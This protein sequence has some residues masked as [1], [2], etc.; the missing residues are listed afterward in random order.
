M[1]NSFLHMDCVYLGLPVIVS[2]K[3]GAFPGMIR[4]MRCLYTPH[5]GS[6]STLVQVNIYGEFLMVLFAWLHSQIANGSRPL[7]IKTFY[8]DNPTHI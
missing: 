8:K 2:D 1:L 6:I 7:A 5:T 3:E 4:C